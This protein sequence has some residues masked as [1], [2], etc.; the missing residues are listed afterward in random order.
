MLFFS[1]LF[2]SS[3]HFAQVGSTA[4]AMGGSGIAS[5]HP[6]ESAFLNPAGIAE[7]SSIYF[8]GLFFNGKTSLGNN[9]QWGATIADASPEN[10]FAG[11]LAYRHRTFE[12]APEDVEEQDFIFT[13]AF[14]PHK[15]IAIGAHVYKKQTRGFFND[16][17]QYNGDIGG[18]FMLSKS[19]ALGFTQFGVVGTKKMPVVGTGLTN[20][21]TVGAQWAPYSFLALTGDVSMY[22]ERNPN[23]RFIH[24]FGAAFSHVEFAH[25]HFGGRFDDARG[26]T[27]YTL[28]LLFDGP[29][30]KIGYS[31]QK[32]VRQ[33]LGEMHTIDISLNL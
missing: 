7:F 6:I 26:E 20:K 11:S 25:I 14:K 8:S 15:Q 10:V 18:L 22:N 12:L 2:F 21:T 1:F 17:D 9:R 19:L 27:Y 32:E 4:D 28:G 24:A 13:G 30:L 31:Y 3:F 29:K 23:G 33:E 5:A 16:V